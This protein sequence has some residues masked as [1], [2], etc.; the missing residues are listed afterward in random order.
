MRQP[1]G[2]RRVEAV[3]FENFVGQEAVAPAVGGM[4]MRDVAAEC[5]EQGAGFVGVLQVERGVLQGGLYL[6]R[7][8]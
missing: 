8:V 4:E 3:G 5:A 1:R 6:L 2:Q 7:G